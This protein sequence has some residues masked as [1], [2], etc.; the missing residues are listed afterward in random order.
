MHMP[1]EN[2]STRAHHNGVKPLPLFRP[3]ALEHQQQKSYGEIILIRPL[4]LMLLTWLS[5]AIVAVA[6]AFLALGHYTEK[7]RVAGSM[8]SE[9]G[10]PGSS[11]AGLRAELYVPGRS[12]PFFAPGRQVV[13]RCRSCPAQF[14]EQTGTVL[15]IS[16]APLDPAEVLPAGLPSSGPAYKITVSLPPPVAQIAELSR[17]PQAGMRVEAEIPLGRKPLIRWFFERS[18]S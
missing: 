8:V 6:L 17:P 14:A 15:G 13:V 5:L 11:A 12:L 3:E 7:V 18:G 16:D 1:G 10:V 2:Q 9:P 4:S